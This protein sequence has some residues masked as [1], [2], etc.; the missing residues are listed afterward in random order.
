MMSY[1]KESAFW[2]D[3]YDRSVVNYESD[4]LLLVDDR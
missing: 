4:L 2:Q 1:C 3:V